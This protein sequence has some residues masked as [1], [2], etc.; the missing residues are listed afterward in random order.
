MVMLYTLSSTWIKK[1]CRNR[2]YQKTTNSYYYYY[3]VLCLGVSKIPLLKKRSNSQSICLLRYKFLDGWS[4]QPGVLMKMDKAFFKY[5]SNCFC[6]FIATFSDLLNSFLDGNT[7][8]PISKYFFF[9]S[10]CSSL[11]LLYLLNIP[12]FSSPTAI[13][14]SNS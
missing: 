7:S 4:G 11:N 10:W 6:C 13:W 12:H 9:Q 14:T 1:C 2:Y 8:S 5:T 3:E